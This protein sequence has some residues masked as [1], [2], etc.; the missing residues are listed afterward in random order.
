MNLRQ[1]ALCHDVTAKSTLEA[2]PLSVH[3]KRPY[4]RLELGTGGHRSRCSQSSSSEG[5]KIGRLP[6]SGWS[7]PAP[8]TPCNAQYPV[9]SSSNTSTFCNTPPS[10]SNC[11][12]LLK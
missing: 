11:V 4:G 1:N 7:K 9:V 3:A 10:T 12:F 6:K 5:R 8:V 2:T